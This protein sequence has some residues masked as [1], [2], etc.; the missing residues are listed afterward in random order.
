MDILK[1]NRSKTAENF[2]E[3]V[4]LSWNVPDLNQ[5]ESD[6]TSYSNHL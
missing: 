1:T 4:I 2:E 5:K 3:T 6:M